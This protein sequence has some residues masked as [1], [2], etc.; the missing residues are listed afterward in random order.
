MSMFMGHDAVAEAIDI[1]KYLWHTLQGC[2]TS[3]FT[4]VSVLSWSH[5]IISLSLV[6]NDFWWF[7]SLL[8]TDKG[9]GRSL[10]KSKGPFVL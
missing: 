8:D 10:D 7:G 9:L 5:I 6:N 1:E 4:A 2:I 3:E